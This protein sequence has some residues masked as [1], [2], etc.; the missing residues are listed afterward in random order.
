MPALD[1]LLLVESV[2]MLSGQLR[3]WFAAL[4]PGW[5]HSCPLGEASAYV[6]GW[7]LC[8]DPTSDSSFI[9]F[10]S[11]VIMP[12]IMPG[13]EKP[14]PLSAQRPRRSLSCYECGSGLYQGHKWKAVSKATLVRGSLIQG[15]GQL[16]LSE[17][18]LS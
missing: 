14:Q 9:I 17:E 11:T 1:I 10:P 8:F 13:N 16:R 7:T 5:I 12:L 2:L 15:L 3:A 4:A 6:C 18:P